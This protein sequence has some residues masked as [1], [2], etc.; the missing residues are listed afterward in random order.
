MTNFSNIILQV[1]K[2]KEE[3]R[4]KERR[5][6]KEKEKVSSI[7]TVIDFKDSDA[8]TLYG[9]KILYFLIKG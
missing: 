8:V 9:E 4:A 1:R 7:S 3:A 5:Q 2:K 6:E